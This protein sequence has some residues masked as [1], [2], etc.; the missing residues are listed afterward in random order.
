MAHG[1]RGD[2]DAAAEAEGLR[3]H[4]SHRSKTG[5]LGVM[6]DVSLSDTSPPLSR[7]PSR[8]P[9]TTA[10]DGE[11]VGEADAASIVTEAEGLRLH[12]SPRSKTGYLGVLRMPNLP[13]GQPR[14]KPFRARYGGD[15]RSVSLGLFASAVEAAVAYANHIA[16]DGEAA[17]KADA[18]GIVTE[19]E[20]MRLHL[21]PHSKT[22]YL[23]VYRMPNY[24]SGQPPAKPFEAQY[25]RD[26]RKVSLGYFATAVEAAVAFSRH[27]DRKSVV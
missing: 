15:G 8:I 26:V 25:G 23:G 14:A 7:P 3:L 17:G 19:A 1:L 12:L 18:E 5:Y 16:R 4:L 27:I 6:G 9:G 21:S 11:A 10:R 24:P 20:G 2:V 13:S 22:G